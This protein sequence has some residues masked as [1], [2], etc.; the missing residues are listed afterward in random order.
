MTGEQLIRK[1]AAMRGNRHY[2]DAINEIE[3]N[4]AA[5]DDITMLPALIQAF[6][7]A[8][9]LGDDDQARKYAREI[10]ILEPE[11]PSIQSFI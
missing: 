5:F 4:R 6:Y 11:L 3:S 7:A 8:K 9:E 10:S 2:Q 1:A